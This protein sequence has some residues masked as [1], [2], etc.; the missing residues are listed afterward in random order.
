MAKQKDDTHLTREEMRE[1]L[2]DEVKLVMKAADLQVR[3]ATDF[4]TAYIAGRINAEEASNRMFRYDCRWGESKLIAAMSD[5]KMSDE[6]ILRRRDEEISTL[7][8]PDLATGSSLWTERQ[9]P[10]R[11]GK[12]R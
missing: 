6:D 2:H 5:D 12:N 10:R 11:R 9:R 1:W 7:L 8:G 4:A 3:D